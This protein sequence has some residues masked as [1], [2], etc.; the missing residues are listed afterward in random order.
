MGTQ[1][2]YCEYCG[3]RYPSVQQ[4]TNG[5]CPR[6]PDGSNR[7]K[8]KLYEGGEKKK[9]TCKHC[10]KEYPT[11]AA[12]VIGPCPRHPM[13]SNHGKHAPAL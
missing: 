2:F 7:G 3:K 4:L 5:L 12:M 6:H 9:Y 11:I 13:G 1:N 8:H 10:G